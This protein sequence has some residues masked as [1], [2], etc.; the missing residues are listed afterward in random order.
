[1]SDS[2]TNVLKYFI[3]KILVYP[4]LPHYTVISSK[5]RF[6]TINIQKGFHYE[7]TYHR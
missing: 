5:N 3:K 2:K 4:P 1:M 6:N 7:I